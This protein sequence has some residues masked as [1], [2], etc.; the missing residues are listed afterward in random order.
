RAG[1]KDIIGREMKRIFD[2]SSEE[3]AR[4]RFNSSK[5]NG[6][7]NILRQYT[8]WKTGW[9]FSWHTTDIQNR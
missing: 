3:E 8:I 1:D 9:T 2:A 7:I 6:T 5:K 4:R